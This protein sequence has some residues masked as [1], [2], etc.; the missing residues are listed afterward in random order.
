MSVSATFRGALSAIAP[1]A[2]TV[3]TDLDYVVQDSAVR[4][5]LEWRSAP[6][7]TWPAGTEDEEWHGDESPG[8]WILVRLSPAGADSTS[9]QVFSKALC[10]ATA[11]SSKVESMLE[12][13]AVV[14]FAST[15]SKKIPRPEQPSNKRMDAAS[16][17][18]RKEMTIVRL[19][20]IRVR[21]PIGVGGE[22]V[23]SQVMR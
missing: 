23:G 9:F 11:D 3:F 17:Y 2:R 5:R 12:T 10:R 18:A 19:A 6:K 20:L 4:Q 22:R 14:E 16:A 21:S 8:V 13:I 1:I 7:F 15:L